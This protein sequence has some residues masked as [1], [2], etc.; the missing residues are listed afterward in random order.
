MTRSE[1]E[2]A[3]AGGSKWVRP[4][5]PQFSFG[6]DLVM[7]YAVTVV[8][9]ASLELASADRTTRTVHMSTV[10]S[11]EALAVL[12]HE[13]GHVE[14]ATHGEQQARTVAYEDGTQMQE[15]L[16]GELVA[17]RFALARLGRSRWNAAM[18]RHMIGCLRTYQRSLVTTWKQVEIL[19]AVI[20]EGR[21]LASGIIELRPKAPTDV[22]ALRRYRE[23]VV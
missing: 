2:V 15:S 10:D 7:R 23:R 12:A 14:D 11:D 13:I 9:I 5:Y 22:T 17:W 21:R 4:S 19:E 8:P 6:V 3:L 18:Q 16:E 20:E 1:V